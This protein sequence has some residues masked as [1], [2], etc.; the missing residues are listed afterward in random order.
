M[1]AHMAYIECMN[2]EWDE[3]KRRSNLLKHGVDFADAVEVFFDDCAL[4]IEDPH[5]P[6]EQRFV[7]LGMDAGL[8]VLVVVNAYRD[9]DTIRLISARKADRKERRHYEG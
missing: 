9:G 8:R 1:Y 2:F 5:A 4:T 6:G 3:T 7:T